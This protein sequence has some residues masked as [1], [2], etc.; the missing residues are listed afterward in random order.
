MGPPAENQDFL[1]AMEA[2]IEVTPDICYATASGLSQRLDFFAQ[3]SPGPHPTLLYF[4]GGGWM[5]G[6]KL[7]G[8]G[9]ILPWLGRGWNVAN[10]NYRLGPTAR[11]PAAVEDARTAFYWLFLNAQRLGVDP[12]KIV[13]A[14]E[15]AGAHL[16]LMV[17]LIPERH[18]FDNACRHSVA[19]TSEM[20]TRR[21]A[22]GGNAA[23]FGQ[24]PKI[25]AVINFYGIANLET[26][27]AGAAA[28]GFALA[29][30]GQE[31]GNDAMISMLSPL[32]YISSKSP[33]VFSVHGDRD[34]IVP[35][36]NAVQLHEKLRACGVRE[37]LII[38]SGA[39]H[40]NFER[41][42]LAD[43]RQRAVAFPL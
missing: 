32:Q 1:D 28:K 42:T 23:W 4:H 2:L 22:S 39:G 21:I 38:L 36:E 20:E 31:A 14:G 11:A 16:A 6:D 34:P 30:L 33:P 41:L 8:M 12:A 37:E 35:V 13:T 25:H 7:Q 17:A 27:V 9:A 18:P 3:R 29:W 5:A 40:G 24:P 26:V 19:I 10:V 15:S 43:V